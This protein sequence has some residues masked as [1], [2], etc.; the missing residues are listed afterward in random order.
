MKSTDS[1][2]NSQ[3][4]LVLAKSRVAPVQTIRLP[5]LELCGGLLLANLMR[6]MGDELKVS[7]LYCWTD[8]SITLAWID[9]SPDKH[10]TFVANRISEIQSLTNSKYWRHVDTKQN[11]ADCLSR[12][13]DAEELKS[14]DLWWHGPKW[15]VNTKENWPRNPNVKI[16]E[17]QF[18]LKGVK[19]LVTA[20]DSFLSNLSNR[21]SSFQK[22]A[23]ITARIRRV[24]SKSIPKSKA[25]LVKEIE[26]EKIFWIKLAQ[27]S[28]FS[29][30]I[31][32]LRERNPLENKSKLLN[33]NPFLDKN[34][35]LR[36]GGRLGIKCRKLR[37]HSLKLYL[38]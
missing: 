33:L 34:G 11:P 36:I 32:A 9:S 27:K 20:G 24:F 38:I 30:E 26:N 31:K 14:H 5:R 19:V 3:V 35:L 10:K 21:Y 16:P 23:R 28:V 1:H 6:V 4:N 7:E 15:L 37:K 25:L 18:E 8:S 13:V 2:G 29:K 12:G 17:D 22:L